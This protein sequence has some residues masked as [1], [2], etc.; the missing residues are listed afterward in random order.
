VEERVPGS[1]Q[2]WDGKS[3]AR[4]VRERDFTSGIVYIGI[5]WIELGNG[6]GWDGKA[7]LGWAAEKDGGRVYLRAS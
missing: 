2:E 6:T 7:E 3:W 4:D 5:W 1:D